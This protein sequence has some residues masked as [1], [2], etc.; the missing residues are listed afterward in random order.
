MTIMLTNYNYSILV[1]FYRYPHNKMQFILIFVIIYANK[2]DKQYKITF[3]EL[4]ALI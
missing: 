4:Y 1:Y 2:I 3:G